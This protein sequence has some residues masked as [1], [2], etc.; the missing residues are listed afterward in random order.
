MSALGAKSCLQKHHFS[1]PGDIAITCISGTTLC[2]L[3][4]PS[5]TTVEQPVELMA[6]TAT[7]LIIEKLENSAATN[8]KVMLDAEMIIRDSSFS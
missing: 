5:V 3:V 1:I 2:M 8:Q 6:Q 4:H 7:E